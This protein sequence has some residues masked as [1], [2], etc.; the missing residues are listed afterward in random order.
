M[1]KARI[2]KFGEIMT[3]LRQSDVTVDLD[4][5]VKGLENAWAWGALSECL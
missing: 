5:K 2:T 1:I 4:T 3:N